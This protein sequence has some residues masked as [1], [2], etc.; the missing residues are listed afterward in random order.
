VRFTGSLAKIAPRLLPRARLATAPDNARLARVVVRNLDGLVR[1]CLA[2][3]PEAAVVDPPEARERARALLAAI[4]A[5]G[6][7]AP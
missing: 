4:A 1:Q 6:E 5:P 3:G 2:W 7:G